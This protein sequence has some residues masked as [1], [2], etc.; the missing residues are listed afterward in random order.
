MSNRQMTILNNQTS[1]RAPDTHDD[2]V[3]FRGDGEPISPQL[4]SDRL[5]SLLDS[6]SMTPDNYSKGGAISEL[7]SRFAVML[8][9]E[10]SIFMPT[11]T[12]ANH[13]AIRK[14]CGN[15][16]RAIVQEQSHLYNDTGDCTTRLSG[17]NLLPLAKDLPCFTVDDVKSTIRKS[18]GGRVSNQ[19]GALLVE[20]P[21]RRQMGQ[22]MSFDDMKKVT[23]LCREHGIA[24][25]L[26]GARIYMMSAASGIA[27][28]KYCELFDTVYV[29]LYKYF[30]APFGAILAGSHTVI[31]DMFHDRRMFGGGLA[32]AYPAA[33]LA[34][35]GVEGFEQRFTQSIKKGRDLFT[36]LNLISGIEIKEFELGSNIFPLSFDSDIDITKMAF[37]LQ[38]RGIYIYP[39][40]GSERYSQLTVNTTI[41][42]KT[43]EQIVQ[44]FRE[45]LRQF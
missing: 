10:A 13:L 11:G 38:E 4:L 7:E 3:I 21:V 39:E 35:H 33:A 9:K 12:L 19:I 41:L 14:L 34:L 31:D 17:I 25:H 43:N 6:V 8:G 40:E 45:T 44:T 1:N 36:D 15:K 30:G 5:A 42:R 37:K 18:E 26:D 28:K 29:S 24:T 27:I 23:S 16:P 32:G 20:S 2:S 22:I